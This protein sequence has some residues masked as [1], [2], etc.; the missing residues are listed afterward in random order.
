MDGDGDLDASPAST[1]C[2][3]LTGTHL[4]IIALVALASRRQCHGLIAGPASAVSPL[5]WR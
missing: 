4:A 2:C 3:S 5:R 1:S